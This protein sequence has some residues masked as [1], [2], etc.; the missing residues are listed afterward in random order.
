MY[1]LE[2]EPSPSEIE[3]EITMQPASKGRRF[4]NYLIDTIAYFVALWI[5]IMIFVIT[6]SLAQ[7]SYDHSA[8]FNTLPGLSPIILYVPFYIFCE[9]APEAEASENLLPK[10]RLQSW[11]DAGLP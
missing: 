3:L 9:W 6:W 1:P 5:L 7:G 11:M 10:Q 4:A 8:T 2:N